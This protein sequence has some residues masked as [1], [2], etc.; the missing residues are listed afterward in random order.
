MV[1][2]SRWQKSAAG[3][4]CPPLLRWYLMDTALTQASV[5]SSS[6]AKST[7]G[8]WVS[9]AILQ[10]A[11]STR[12]QRWEAPH[13]SP[14]SASVVSVCSRVWCQ[15]ALTDPDTVPCSRLLASTVGAI[16][17]AQS[18]WWRLPE[19]ANAGSVG[20]TISSPGGI[21][22]LQSVDGLSVDW[23]I[24]RGGGFGLRAVPNGNE[25]SVR[26]SL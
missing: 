7:V 21:L 2:R 12:R 6:Q 9:T 14:L 20:S 24:R 22:G 17:A 5:A 16:E 23:R 10:T 25:W 3:T 19:W 15:S 11:S 13:R 8:G 18:R 1:H 4:P 26:L